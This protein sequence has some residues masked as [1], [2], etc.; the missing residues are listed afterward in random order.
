MK[1]ATSLCRSR[2]STV[3]QRRTSNAP[4]IANNGITPTI[5][6]LQNNPPTSDILRTS[7]YPGTVCQRRR[8]GESIDRRPAQSEHVRS[9]SLADMSQSLQ[10]VR[11]TLQSG[12][13]NLEIDVC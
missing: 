7:R 9:G 1:P 11:F 8:L 13:P 3:T 4:A 5:R 2:T 12:M 6:M 10:D